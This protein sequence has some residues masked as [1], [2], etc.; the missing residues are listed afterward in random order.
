V[1]ASTGEYVGSVRDRLLFELLECSGMRLGEALGL[2]HGDWVTGR[3]DTPYVNS[4][5]R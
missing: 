1:D 3:G 2:L 4:G 5:E